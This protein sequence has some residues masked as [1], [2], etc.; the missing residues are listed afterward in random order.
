MTNV[1]TPYHGDKSYYI[2]THL[3][4]EFAYKPIRP[5]QPFILSI[6]NLSSIPIFFS[7]SRS[8][9]FYQFNSHTKPIRPSVNNSSVRLL[10]NSFIYQSCSNSS[11]IT[12]LVH[13]PIWPFVRSSFCQFDH[14]PIRP[15]A[16]STIF[17]TQI[18]PLSTHQCMNIKI[19]L[20]N[21]A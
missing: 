6:A 9:S 4:S 3:Y 2:T 13:Y 17:G 11:C 7:F 15:F 12:K 19:R 18:I 1:W 14:L 20:L 16:N 5:F 10:A 8:S 21:V